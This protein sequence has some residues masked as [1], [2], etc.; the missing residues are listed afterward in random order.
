MDPYD[1]L[2]YESDHPVGALR[3]P[4]L[5]SGISIF[6]QL[7]LRESFSVCN[8]AAMGRWERRN[9][10]ITSLRSAR[11]NDF[12]NLPIDSQGSRKLPSRHEW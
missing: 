4:R 7:I 3:R 2:R 5:M 11:S 9:Q 6:H 8:V 10:E 12:L 1:Y